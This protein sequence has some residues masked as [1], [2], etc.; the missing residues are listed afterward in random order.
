MLHTW[1]ATLL[2]LQT[3]QYILHS[4]KLFTSPLESGLNTAIVYQEFTFWIQPCF[5]QHILS[6]ALS[7]YTPVIFL[8]FQLLDV[9]KFFSSGS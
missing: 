8:F 4:A 9:T 7:F 2:R 3:L 1:Q 6:L 5:W